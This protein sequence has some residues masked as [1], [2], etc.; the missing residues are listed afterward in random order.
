MAEEK[1]TDPIAG[2]VETVATEKTPETKKQIAVEPV[3]AAYKRCLGEK[4]LAQQDRSPA[5]SRWEDYEITVEICCPIDVPATIGGS[6]REFNQ[7]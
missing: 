2:I 1:S 6:A 4:K 7:E 3:P 5:C